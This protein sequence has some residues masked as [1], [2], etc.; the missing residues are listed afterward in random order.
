[1]TNI[2]FSGLTALVTGGTSGI[3][4]EVALQLGAGGAHVVVTGRSA[5]R[6]AATVDAIVAAGGAADFVAVDLADAAAVTHLAAEALRIGGGRVDVLVNN[7]GLFPFGAT[8]DADTEMFDSVMAVN[9]RAPFTLVGALAPGMAERGHGAIVNV[10]TMVAAFG[11]SGMSLYGSSKAAL[12]LLTKAWAAEFGASG[13]RVN[14]V[15]PGPT[16]TEGTEVMGES[17][18][19]LAATTP[20]GRPSTPAEVAAGIVFLASA[21]ASNIHGVILPVDGGRLAV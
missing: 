4:R 11:M 1:M 19:A 14:A 9:V 17:L 2:D 3:G 13:V 5:E 20:A 12:Q 6:G 21:A 18:D 8:A 16:R 7:A 10:T 15:S